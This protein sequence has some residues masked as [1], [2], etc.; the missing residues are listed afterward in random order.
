MFQGGILIDH[1][2]YRLSHSPYK[3]KNIRQPGV[4]REWV[5][6]MVFN[7]NLCSLYSSLSHD[8]DLNVTE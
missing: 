1:C 8:E 7:T 5:T 4:L 3:Q 2:S 6:D